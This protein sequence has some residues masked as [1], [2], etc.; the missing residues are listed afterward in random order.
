MPDL[1]P[2]FIN[3]LIKLASKDKKIIFIVGDVGYSFAEKFIGKFPEQ[4]LN[5][6][7]MEQSMLG[8]AAGMAMSGKK[9]Y[10]YSMINF[11]L[12]RPYEQLRNDICYQNLNVKIIGVKGSEAYRFLGFSHNIKE[13]EDLKILEPFPNISCYTPQN[14]K[15]V[16]RIILKTYQKN[17]PV[18]IRL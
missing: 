14:T 15:E 13:N 4:F 1:R 9:P 5:C 6:G 12:M 8:I 3:E 7:V 10:V 11:V 17:N 16:K 18:Y 2:S